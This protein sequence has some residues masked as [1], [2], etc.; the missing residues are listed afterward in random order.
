MPA[1]QRIALLVLLALSMLVRP[2]TADDRELIYSVEAGGLE[3]AELEA[4]VERTAQAIR[5]RLAQHELDAAEV[6][7]EAEGRLTVRWSGTTDA[8]RADWRERILVELGRPAGGLEMLIV[9]EP[10]LDPVDLSA[11]RGRLAK[12]L[13]KWKQ[14][15]G[16]IVDKTAP[17]AELVVEDHEGNRY[18]WAPYAEDMVQ[19]DESDEYVLLRLAERS[20]TNRDLETVEE[21]SDYGD[22][23]VHV[24]FKDASAQ[25]F[26]DFTEANTGRKLAFVVGGFVVTSPQLAGRME[27]H[28]RIHSGRVSGFTAEEA[29][30]MVQAIQREQLPAK[31]T[32]VEG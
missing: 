7:A 32:L 10:D 11:E 27:K 30:M 16:V 13:A 5:T 29:E 20:F 2:A 1:P 28:A 15:H 19:Q 22:W 14:E 23:V 26:G 9:A 4:L 6:Q 12:T 18:R 3:G 8:P 17:V 24:A 25:A 21:Q 31:L